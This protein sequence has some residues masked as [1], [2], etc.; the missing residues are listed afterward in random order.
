MKNGR[1]HLEKSSVKN[2]EE[3][4]LWPSFH[5]CCLETG[6]LA[7]GVGHCDG[8]H[9]R[10]SNPDDYRQVVLL[11]ATIKLIFIVIQ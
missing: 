4:G 3:E 9:N 2:E 5:L 10:Q 6:P 11:L 1:L 7:E 8:S